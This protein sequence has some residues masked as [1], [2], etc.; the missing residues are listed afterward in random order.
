MLDHEIHVIKSFF[1]LANFIL[2]RFASATLFA[3]NSMHF[4]GF[5]VS[6]PMCLLPSAIYLT[7]GPLVM[8][9]CSNAG[10]PLALPRM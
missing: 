10:S 3:V 1:L 4:F 6:D 8:H 9:D 7:K 2:S 5:Y